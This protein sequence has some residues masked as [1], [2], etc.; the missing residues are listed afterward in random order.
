[1]TRIDPTI[2][3]LKQGTGTGPRTGTASTTAP[4]Q[5]RAV[6]LA[7][8]P[9]SLA[10]L[11]VGSIVEGIVIGPDA[12]GLIQVRTDHGMISF[13]T[14][15]SLP[16][17]SQV[18]LQVRTAGSQIQVAILSVTPPGPEGAPKG[19]QG[20]TQSAAPSTGS[21]GVPAQLN[22]VLGLV[23]EWPALGEALAVLQG[24]G[25]PAAQMLEML[26][27][28]PNPQIASTLLFFVAALTRGDLRTFLGREIGKALT[29]AGRADLSGRLA[30]DFGQ[31]SRLAAGTDSSEWR[32]FLLPIADAGRIEQIRLFLKRH[33]AAQGEE[34]DQPMTRFVFE[35]GLS[36]LGRI[37]LDGLAGGDR[38]DL[39]V[40]TI[41]PLSDQVKAEIR[42][43]FGNAREAGKL[44][45]EIA[46]QT[47][48]AFSLAPLEEA[49][50]SESG[51]VV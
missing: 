47:V 48:A 4:S 27:S 39:M 14:P 11:T 30:D 23:Q 44:A 32:T 15:I 40:R 22:P 29:E 10:R 8:S 41:E 9:A 12:R 34:D 43:I 6:T 36:R 16:A 49:L 5:A 45:G 17:G 46:F 42:A 38:F 26:V 3:F 31:L 35:V 28:R 20:A 18:V 25:S 24:A 19:A 13:R 7:D 21:S 50:A 37:Q 33:R 51:V 1:M 2:S